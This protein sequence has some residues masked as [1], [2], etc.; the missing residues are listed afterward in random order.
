MSDS[1]GPSPD[2]PAPFWDQ[3]FAETGFAYGDQPNDFVREQAA[4][5]PVGRAL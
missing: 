3:R 1:A 4:L 2:D 5:L